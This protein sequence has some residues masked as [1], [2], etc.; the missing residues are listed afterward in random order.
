MLNLVPR[1]KEVSETGAD[2]ATKGD[3]AVIDR[4]GLRDAS[5]EQVVDA[6]NNKR[7]VTAKVLRRKTLPK[8]G[9]YVVLQTDPENPRLTK[10]QSYEISIDASVTI[11]GR[12]PAGLFYGVQTF[13]QILC[14]SGKVIPGT[15]IRDWPD[16]TE[17]ILMY[18]FARQQ[19]VRM[20]FM[21]E[22]LTRLA[23]LKYNKF[24][25]YL[26]GRF[27][28][29]SHPTIG[30][31]GAMTP[32]QVRELESFAKRLHIEIV[33]HFNC[34]GHDE[35]LLNNPLYKHLAEDE[36]EPAQFCPSNP[37]ALR[38]IK[39]LTR[40]IAQAF[41]SELFHVGGNGASQLGLCH[42]CAKAVERK[43]PAA[44]YSRHYLKIFDHL[45][46]LGKKPVM[47]A[48]ELLVHREVAELFPKDVIIYDRHYNGSSPETVR[49]LVEQGFSVTVCP[50]G[51]AYKSGTVSYDIPT[52]NIL[53][54]LPDAYRL[55]V[56][57]FCITMWELYHG[58]CMQNGWY[59]VALAADA[60]WDTVHAKLSTGH[61]RSFQRRFSHA[62]LGTTKTSFFDYLR[63]LA[64]GEGDLYRTMLA[65]SSEFRRA[66]FSDPDPFFLYLRLSRD[67]KTKDKQRWSRFFRKAKRLLAKAKGEA[68]SGKELF[69]M[70]DFPL[71]MLHAG[72]R[73]VTGIQAASDL[74]RK[75]YTK[76]STLQPATIR[77]GL[78]R[79]RQ[80]IDGCASDCETLE[81]RLVAIHRDYGA[82]WGDVL[83]MR[84]HAAHFKTYARYIRHHE[85]G[86]GKGVSLVEPSALYF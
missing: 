46:N 62:I 8:S 82:H 24:I 48:D 5:V 81:K 22:V 11:T 60:A 64:H 36:W 54:F 17:R 67:L 27:A 63:L 74:Y 85:R 13:K 40:D 84:R 83:Q 6:L 19:H 3:I 7:N 41:S 68:K 2:F 30:P 78:A 86:I 18:D 56:R 57:S 31:R 58:N 35:I 9:K 49:F 77:R 43:G 32:S 33:P 20:D 65:Y 66:F 47:W 59:P 51:S 10:P 53:T 37:K 4:V 23:E 34:L 12:D 52:R 26:E 16:Y 80:L 71:M 69:E 42:K 44:L 79:C 15:L 70:L 38:L 75:L 25:C 29:K 28:F 76:Q 72:Y 21:K 14:M 61:L 73:R 50:S 39:D 1:P 55:G 45:K